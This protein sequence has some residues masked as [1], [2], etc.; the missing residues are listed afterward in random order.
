[1][2]YLEPGNRN[3]FVA[4]CNQHANGDTH[5][6]PLGNSHANSHTHPNPYSHGDPDFDAH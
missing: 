4:N 5:A 3:C 6:N 1:M 2:G